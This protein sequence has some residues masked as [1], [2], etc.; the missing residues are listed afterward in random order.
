MAGFEVSTVS[1][2]T[3]SVLIAPSPSRR[4]SGLKAMVVS[5][6]SYLASSSS[7]ASPTSWTIV[8][9]S[10]PEDVIVSRIGA[11]SRSR[12]MSRTRLTASMRASRAT[13]SRLGYPLGISCW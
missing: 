12:P 4:N 6:P 8:V 13:T 11:L 2:E 10:S 9:S 1:S 3:S 5:L 7:L